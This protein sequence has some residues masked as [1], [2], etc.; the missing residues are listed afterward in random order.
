[1][2]GGCQSGNPIFTE[3]PVGVKA[4][5]ESSQPAAVTAT[6][7]HGTGKEKAIPTGLNQKMSLTVKDHLM[8]KTLLLSIQITRFK[9]SEF[10]RCR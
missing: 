3:N 6:T 5:A 8:S 1:L 9:P 10:S 7:P 4:F 2:S